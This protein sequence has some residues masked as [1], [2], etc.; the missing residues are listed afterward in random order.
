MIM[1]KYQLHVNLKQG[2]AEMAASTVQDSPAQFF[3]LGVSSNPS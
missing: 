2:L 1:Q 3:P